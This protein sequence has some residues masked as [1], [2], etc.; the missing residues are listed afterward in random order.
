MLAQSDDDMREIADAERV[1]E[2]KNNRNGLDENELISNKSR[3]NTFLIFSAT[4]RSPQWTPLLCSDQDPLQCLT[5]QQYC[6]C[7]SMS[8]TASQYV[9]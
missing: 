1:A 4:E 9:S 2:H 8:H 7:T 6:G 5:A 3:R